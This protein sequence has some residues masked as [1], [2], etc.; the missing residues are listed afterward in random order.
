MILEYSPRE[1]ADVLSGKCDGLDRCP[2]LAVFNRSFSL[3]TLKYYS[4]LSLIDIYRDDE[5]LEIDFLF[6][7]PRG[8]DFVMAL[9]RSLS[10][11]SHSLSGDRDMVE[12]ITAYENDTRLTCPAWIVTIRIWNVVGYIDEFATWLSEGLVMAE[13][14]L[15]ERRTNHPVA[16]NTTARPRRTVSGSKS[17]EYITRT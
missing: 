16:R 8:R 7:T 9:F 2:T 13:R 15:N 17:S 5:V 14:I 11:T 1:D 4:D 10:L 3:A 6:H 12:M